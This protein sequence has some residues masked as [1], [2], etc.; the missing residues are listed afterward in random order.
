MLGKTIRKGPPKMADRKYSPPLLFWSVAQV[1][2][3]AKGV[4]YLYYIKIWCLAASI[5][6]RGILGSIGSRST[7][8]KNAELQYFILT[9]KPINNSINFLFKSHARRRSKIFQ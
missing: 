7:E 2:A 6:F 8:I 3:C 4:A 1:S 5:N 9:F